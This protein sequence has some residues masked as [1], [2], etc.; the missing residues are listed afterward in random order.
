MA[1]GQ[2]L[3]NVPFGDMVFQLGS[4]IADSQRKLDLNSVEVLKDMV[5]APPTK[6]PDISDPKQEIEVPILAL[7]YLSVSCLRKQI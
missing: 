1:I 7:G 2:D 6:L 5:Q 4:A 3:L